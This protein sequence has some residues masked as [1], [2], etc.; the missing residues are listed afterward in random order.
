M[1]GFTQNHPTVENDDLRREVPTLRL[2]LA[3][4]VGRVNDVSRL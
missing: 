4:L 2:T 3:A 1:I